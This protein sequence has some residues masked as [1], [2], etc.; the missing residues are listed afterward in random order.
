[1]FAFVIYSFFLTQT[2]NNSAFPAFLSRTMKV[3]WK[4]TAQLMTGTFSIALKCQEKVKGELNGENILNLIIVFFS[5]DQ[6]LNI[7]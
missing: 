7:C 3:S 4:Q 1:M 6:I 5:F 2:Q